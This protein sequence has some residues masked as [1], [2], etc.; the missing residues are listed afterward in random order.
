MDLGNTLPGVAAGQWVPS[1]V[2]AVWQHLA[3]QGSAYSAGAQLLL[4]RP[5][6]KL[7][8]FTGLLWPLSLAKYS[9]RILLEEKEGN[10]KT[11]PRMET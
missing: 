6:L 5:G 2:T 11:K 3:I 1:D 8:F 9:C 7:V 10:A 4:P